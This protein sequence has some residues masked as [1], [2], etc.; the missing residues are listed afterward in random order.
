MKATPENKIKTQIKAFLKASGVYW[1]SA[2][3]GPYS[4]GGIPDYIGSARGRFFGIEAKSPTGKPTALQ[5]RQK[6]LIED[7][8]GAWFLVRDEAS[9]EGVVEWLKSLD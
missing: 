4:V 5:L 6:A 7:S 2:A 9:L 8:G 1:Y 3:A